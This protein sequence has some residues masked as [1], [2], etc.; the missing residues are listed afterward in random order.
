M[1]L[2][3]SWYL[4]WCLAIKNLRARWDVLF[5]FLLIL[6]YIHLFYL[7]LFRTLY[8]VLTSKSIDFP[9]NGKPGHLKIGFNWSRH[10]LLAIL[11]CDWYRI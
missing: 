8:F 6:Y 9:F 10:L 11:Q 5:C 4:W 7:D 2:F 1:Y 3:Q